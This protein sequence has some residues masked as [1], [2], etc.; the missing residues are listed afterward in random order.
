MRV[1][2]ISAVSIPDDDPKTVRVFLR[3][4]NAFFNIKCKSIK[5]SLDVFENIK[6]II[7]NDGEDKAPQPQAPESYKDRMKAEYLEL[8]DRISRLR[9]F[10]NSKKYEELS[11]EYEELLTGQYAAMC[12]YLDCLRER[13]V[14]E[15]IMA[16]DKEDPSNE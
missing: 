3:A 1:A 12:D 7:L 16:E 8:N 2:E 10:L 13:C 5:E 15:G 14:M 9:L 6:D 11:P 4:T